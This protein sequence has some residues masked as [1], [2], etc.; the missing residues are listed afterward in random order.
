MKKYLALTLAIVMA[1]SLA[2]CGKKPAQSASSTAGSSSAQ[3]QETITLG[4][5]AD[6]PPFEFHVLVDGVDTIVG[7][8]VFLAQEIA[9][10]MGKTLDIRDMDFDNLLMLMDK[11]DCDFVIAAMELD[12]EG[13]RLAAADCSDPYFTDV[14]PAIITLAKNVSLY[15]SMDDFNGKTVGAQTATTKEDIVVNDMPGANPLLQSKVTDLVSQLMFEKC[16][17]L[18][19]DG[20]VAQKYVESNPDLAIVEAISLGDAAEPYRVWVKK[21]DPKNLLPAINAT[22]EKAISQGLI[23]SFIEQADELSSQAMA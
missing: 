4:T 5:S 12:A 2:A 9:A 13:T 7:I 11:G 1:L 3:Q 19:L 15:T 22:I 17:A 8:D 21:G 14:P 6:Y 23:T 20:A 10:D 16:D 18:V